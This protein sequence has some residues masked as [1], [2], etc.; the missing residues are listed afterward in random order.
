M[1]FADLFS[2]LAAK[3]FG[4]AP[5]AAGAAADPEL[6]SMGVEAVVE[7]V[8]PRLRTLSGYARRIAPSVT[9]TIAH[10]RE[11]GRL[12]PEPIT[13]SRAAWA[14]DPFLN[15]AFATAD[16]VPLLLG[17]SAELK[18]FFNGNPGAAEA[19]ALL[20]MLKTEREVFAPALV[21]GA[22]QRDVA[23]TTV[24]FSHHR[25]VCAAGDASACKR[26]TGVRILR[27]LAELALKRITELEELATELEQRKAVLGAKLRLLH[28]RSNGLEQ[29]VRDPG[30]LAAQIDAIQRELKTTLDD[31]LETKASA[32]TLEAR[33]YQ[34]EAIFGA[35]AEHMKL[36]R[37]ALRV[38]RLGYKVAAG[39]DEPA[40][41]LGLHEL[42]MG[43]GQQGVIA[44]VRCPRAE[45]P[46]PE[47]LAARG[48]QALL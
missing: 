5:P 40:A 18:D 41:E 2:S 4:A 11:L 39:A 27:R 36:E 24:S 9:R 8:D 42:T 13:L 44:F 34:I 32:Q 17:R 28:L 12:L 38:N 29:I 48:T 19:Y 20:G 45:L 25:L 6:V 35:P 43:D 26:E 3:L 21:G 23:Q 31:Y 14:E 1:A 10:L 47:S 7:A 15:A 16:D 37:V 22:L 33:L 46:S 30:D